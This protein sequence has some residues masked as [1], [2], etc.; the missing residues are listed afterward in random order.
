MAAPILSGPGKDSR[1]VV[2]SETLSLIERARA[3]DESAWAALVQ[4]ENRRL[5]GVLAACLR[6]LAE[7]AELVEDLLQEVHLEAFRNLDRF[8]DRGPGGFARWVAGIARNKARHALRAGRRGV[9]A[10]RLDA[11]GTPTLRSFRT[12]PASGAVKRELR[13]RMMRALDALPDDYRDVIVLRHFEGLD[14]KATAE[15]L[16]RSEGAVR[17]LFFRA[18]AR[19][20]QVLRELGEEAA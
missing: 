15:A 14:G 19:L 12:T 4:R 10:A 8:E 1:G 6:P 16:E 11:T 3:G 17:V 5:I 7:R 9:E 13:S 20:G 18:M 2:D